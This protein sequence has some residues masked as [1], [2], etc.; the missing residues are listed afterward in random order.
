MTKN[1]NNNNNYG[2]APTFARVSI[3]ERHQTEADEECYADE[4]SSGACQAFG[5]LWINP[6]FALVGDTNKPPDTRKSTERPGMDASLDPFI[7]PVPKITTADGKRSLTN[8]NWI[9]QRTRLLH[10]EKQTRQHKTAQDKTAQDKTAQNTLKMG[11]FLRDS[12]GNLVAIE[13]GLVL[14]RTLDRKPRDCESCGFSKW[15]KKDK[16]FIIQG[17]TGISPPQQRRS[18]STDGGGGNGSGGYPPGGSMEW[19][20]PDCAVK[21]GLPVEFYHKNFYSPGNAETRDLHQ[22]QRE[23]EARQE[24]GRNIPQG[25]ERLL[26]LTSS[27]CRF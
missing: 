2:A 4:A 23:Q 14:E 8:N 13:G 10:V 20:C 24:G 11:K 15:V 6:G 17:G 3:M 26:D 22:Q 25:I 18:R 5:P 21:R 19:I 9:R 12:M 27:L 16:V 7:F 1:N